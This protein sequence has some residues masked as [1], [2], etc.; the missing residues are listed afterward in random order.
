MGAIKKNSDAQRAVL[1][2]MMKKVFANIG[3]QPG[4]PKFPGFAKTS[5]RDKFIV[6][7]TTFETIRWNFGDLGFILF[8]I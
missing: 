4:P 2:Q 1:K 5:G 7:G 6:L 3:I 8:Y